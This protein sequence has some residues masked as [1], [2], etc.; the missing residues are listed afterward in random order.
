[1]IPFKRINLGNAYKEVKP[2]FDSGM[3]GLGDVV[4]Q[5]EKELA[6]YLGARFVVALDSCTSAL[7]LSAKWEQGKEGVRKVSIPSMTVPLVADAL[8][9]ANMEFS[10]DNRTDWVGKYYRLEGSGIYDS[11][12]ELRR[13]Q[14]RQMKDN[15][16]PDNLKL[17]FSFYP[18]KTI[19]SA[20]GGAIATDDERFANWARSACVYGR[21]QAQKRQ[22]SWDYDIEMIGYKLHMT[23]LQAA[24]ILEQL[25]RLDQ[26]NAQRQLISEHYDK[27]FS[28]ATGK[29]FHHDSDYLYRLDVKNRD[30]FIE[31]CLKNG[32]ECGVHF[33]PLHQFTPFQDLEISKNDRIA[34]NEAYE[35]T[36]SLPLYD[37]LTPEEVA[38]VIDVV[39]MRKGDLL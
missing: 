4:F 12:H 28:Y 24:I 9:Q 14:F 10:L 8:T 23:N 34:V 1:M 3:I 39:L 11:A 36:V 26:T 18:T 19:G 22:N 29:V 31:H 38:R 21:N 25:H 30:E 2:L 20:D 17:C 15:G 33:K 5:F 7:F 16:A 32:V 27:A 13:N 37:S 35:K 6:E